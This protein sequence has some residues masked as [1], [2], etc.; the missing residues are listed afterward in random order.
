MVGK[1]P[2]I[3]TSH[4]VD[5]CFDLYPEKRRGAG[6][7]ILSIPVHVNEQDQ[8]D[9]GEAEAFLQAYRLNQGLYCHQEDDPANTQ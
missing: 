3:Y 9:P 6:V 8:F 2:S 4:D 5:M 7:R 1:E